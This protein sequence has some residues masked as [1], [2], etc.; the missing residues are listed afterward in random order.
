MNVVAAGLL[1][2]DVL[3]RL[4]RPDRHERVPVIGC[5][6]R[7]HVDILVVKHPANVLHSGRCVAAVRFDLMD[8][9]VKGPGVGIDQ[10][11]DGHPGHLN[12]LIDMRFAAAVEPRHC[13]PDGI[14]RPLTRPVDRVP[15][16]ASPAPAMATERFKNWRRLRLLFDMAL[17][18]SLESRKP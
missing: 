5:G 10:I 13:D 7:D 18:L 4:N 16:M 1:D 11:S 8:A 9:L 17:V 3:P 12:V 6:D 2:I 15:P 14:I